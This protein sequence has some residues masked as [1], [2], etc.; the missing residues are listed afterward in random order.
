MASK[1]KVTREARKIEDRPDPEA[2][3][4]MRQR[5]GQW[6]A[7]HNVDLGHPNCGH[8]QFLKFGE[9]CT[10]TGL[11]KLPEQYPSD[12]AAGGLGWRYRLLGI[13]SMETGEISDMV[14]VAKSMV[15]DGGAP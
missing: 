2:L 9:G 3:A 12:T 6:A 10:F 7:Y 1:K 8:L 5:G 15:R 13:V 14:T 4:Q 11:D